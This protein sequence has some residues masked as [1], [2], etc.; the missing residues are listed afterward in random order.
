MTATVN[1][2]ILPTRLPS[3]DFTWSPTA[4]TFSMII[5]GNSYP[6][7]ADAR[8]AATYT[9]VNTPV[10]LTAVASWDP[11]APIVEY[12]WDTGDGFVKFGSSVTHTFRIPNPHLAVTLE[13]TDILGRKR[14]VSHPMQ[15]TF[16][17][18]LVVDPNITS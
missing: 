18:R 9:P 13:V 10:T 16:T 1:D 5:N 15:L 11:R 8:F 7:T 12:R 6:P 14:S 4:G 17:T 3:V 2:P